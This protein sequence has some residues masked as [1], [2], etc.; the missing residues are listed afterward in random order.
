M[1][2]SRWGAAAAMALLGPLLI[3]RA[4]MAWAPSCEPAERYTLKNGVEVVLVPSA[5]LPTV[6]V[7]SSVHAGSRNDPP[8]YE[9]LAHY[10]EHLTFRS[11]P[12]F[13]SAF[14]L[15]Q[16]IGANGLNAT[17]SPDATEYFALVPASQLE[18]ALWIEA[19]RLGIGLASLDDAGAAE[20]RKVLLREHEW[21]FGWAP[22]FAL[23]RA[24]YENLFPADHPYHAFFATEKSIGQLTLNDARS[25]FARWYR[26]DRTR[27]VLVGDFASESAK[28]LI[29]RYFG[30]LDAGAPATSGKQPE[31]CA[32]A[33]KTLKPLHSRIVLKSLSKNERLEL[34]WPVHAE[35]EAEAVR[36][37]FDL[38][39]GE[40][41][42]AMRQTGLSHQVNAE[43][44]GH[45]LN[46]F[47]VISIDVA[48]GQPFEKIEPLVKRLIAGLR[49]TFADDK[50]L[51]AQ[52]QALEL[53]DLASQTQLL[54]RARYL[55]RRECQSA[56]CLDAAKLLTPSAVN[57]LDRFAPEQAL[58]VERRYSP[59]ASPDGDVEVLP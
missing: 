36:G 11:Q 59:G 15:Y 12:P 14:D 26:P 40:L 21:R 24:T 44:V 17:T 51:A 30:G 48:P 55:A 22:D 32:W 53:S 56:A 20:E 38:L 13:A 27:L 57:Q 9:G 16:E 54:D 50:D 7:V 25:F 29:E 58:V 43:L 6:A 52:R 35:E 46:G 23:T 37:V 47:W 31:E 34:Y 41:S 45:E 4:A 42:A 18:R 2:E 8:G 49:G 3:E 33:K 19:R 39:H 10:V 28:A 5:S 1:N